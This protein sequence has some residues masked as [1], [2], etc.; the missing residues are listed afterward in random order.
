MTVRKTMR[1]DEPRWVIDITYRKPDGTKGR[2][3]R[4]AQVQTSAAARAEERR[5]L[6]QLAQFGDLPTPKTEAPAEPEQ[7]LTFGDAVAL[8][9]EGKA[10]TELK[11]STRKG[12]EEILTKRLLPE[13]ADRPLDE[14]DFA[15]ASSL[16]AALVKEELSASRRRNV[17]IVVRSVLRAAVDAGKLPA[18]PKLPDLPKKG[19]KALLPLTRAQVDAILAASPKPWKL[20]FGLAAFA[21]LRAGEVRAL[22]G[23]DVDL[24]AGLIIVRHS[25]SKGVT[26]TPKSGHEREV[27]I[28]EPLL[29]L[30]AEAGPRSPHALVATTAHGEGWGESGLLQAF[31]RAQKKAGLSGFRFHD[32]RHFFVT[33]LFR[34]GAAAPAVQALAGHL[35]L[36]TTQRYAHMVRKDLK[37]TIG[38]LATR[39]NGVETAGE[40]PR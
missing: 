20:A 33:E 26:S 16:D 38:L 10:I 1:G 40:Q 5:L 13:I 25:T 23:A 37:A 31:R 34:G 35:H 39:G 3:R 11:P 28:A 21:G 29:V 15:Y 22:R 18:M 36:S 8:F 6:A 12:Y 7:R 24:D 4:D 2:Y 14:V 30:L 17:L 27:P 32:L 19:K 9:R